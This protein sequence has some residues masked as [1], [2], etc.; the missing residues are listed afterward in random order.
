MKKTMYLLTVL[1][2]S[3]LITNCSSDDDSGDDGD[4]TA[5][6]LIADWIGVYT[7]SCDANPVTVTVVDFGDDIYL[8]VE[9]TSEDGT[10][11][12]ETS[13]YLNVDNCIASATFSQ[14]ET[15][16]AELDGNNITLYGTELPSLFDSCDSST[17]YTKP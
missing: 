10:S 1:F 16:F 12:Q 6:C 13:G 2:M 11:T 4:G 15:I 14:G 3:L 17:I 5:V 7:G 8:E 9:I